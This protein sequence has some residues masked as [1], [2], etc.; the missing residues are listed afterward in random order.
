M[1]NTWWKIIAFGPSY[2][3]ANIDRKPRQRS[4]RIVYLSHISSRNA[5][6]DLFSAIRVLTSDCCFSRRT[7]QHV[8]RALF[9][10]FKRARLVGIGNSAGP[11]RNIISFII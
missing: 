6:T 5:R 7:I 11:I 8:D 3:R 2:L 4:T 1:T 9:S 10:A